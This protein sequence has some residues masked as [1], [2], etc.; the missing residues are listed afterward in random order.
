IAGPAV[1]TTSIIL[2][3]KFGVLL[4]ILSAIANILIAGVLLF[5]SKILIKLI[6]ST[7]AKTI[8]KIANLIMAAYAVMII[9]KGI[10]LI[11]SSL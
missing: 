9:R 2:V 3:N 10:E 7:G 4:T 5:F 6:S 11:L 1:L 8:S